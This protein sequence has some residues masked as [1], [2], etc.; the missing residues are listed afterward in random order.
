[1]PEFKLQCDESELS[2]FA[3]TFGSE[4]SESDAFQAG[5]EISGGDRSVTNLVKIVKWKSHRRAGLILKN[6][7]LQVKEALDLAVAVANSNSDENLITALET[8]QKLHGVGLPVASA[9]LTAI[10]PERFTIIDFRALEA[11]GHPQQD[12]GF[13]IAY[14]N[15]CRNLAAQKVISPQIELPAPTALRALDRALWQCGLELNQKRKN[16]QS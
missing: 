10:N 9:I 7:A 14:L 15:F 11:L 4:E 16:L 3:R 12:E 1:M 6:T 2:E 13:Y 8:L 5:K